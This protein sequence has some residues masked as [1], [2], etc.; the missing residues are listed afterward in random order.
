[1]NIY[2]DATPALPVKWS[3]G[4]D[5]SHKFL[6]LATAG[7]DHRPDP[8]IV[9]PQ[10]ARLRDGIE[11]VYRQGQE[12]KAEADAKGS[13][14]YR[15]TLGQMA[16]S[17][18]AMQERLVAIEGKPALLMTPEVYRVR[19]E[20]IGRF[21]GQIAGEA[22]REG[23]AAQ[24]TAT[25]ELKEL[26]GRGRSR[27]GQRDWLITTGLAGI[28]VGMGLW[29]LLVENLPWGAGTWLAAVPIAGDKWDAGLELLHEGSPVSYEK[30]V[31]LYNTCGTQTVEFCQ[32]AIAAKTLSAAQGSARPAQADRSRSG[33]HR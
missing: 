29:T 30:M 9:R 20:E 33:A 26:I 1:L 24:S 32:E 8:H 28:I 2:I 17:L 23:A 6:K 22:M 13:V 15:L 12:T 31:T 11:L 7:I 4:G 18:Q 16:K 21:A 25:R 10:V 19:I 27:R 5:M 14:D 3:I